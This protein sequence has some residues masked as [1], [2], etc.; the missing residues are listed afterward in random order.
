MSEKITITGNIA[1]T[2]ERRVTSGGFAVTSFRVASGERRLDKETGQ[3]SDGETSFYKV[4]AYRS[5]A[6]NSYDS[7]HLGDRVIVTGRLRIKDWDTGTKKGTSAEIDVD[8]LG[9]DLL[10]GTSKFRKNERDMPAAGGDAEDEAESDTQAEA[11]AAWSTADIHVP[12]LET[13]GTPY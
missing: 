4:S 6:E 2:P 11:V 13:A 9:H 8:A 12:E 5:L 10:W 1:T 7:F 3:W